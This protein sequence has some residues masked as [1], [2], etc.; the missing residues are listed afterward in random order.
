MD[1]DSGDRSNP[2]QDGENNDSGEQIPIRVSQERHRNEEK[3]PL[4]NRKQ[5]FQSRVTKRKKKSRKWK[6]STSGENPTL[7]TDSSSPSKKKTKAKVG[8]IINQ[9]RHLPQLPAIQVKRTMKKLIIDSCTNTAF[10]FN[11]KIYKQIDKVLMGFPLDPVLAN[12]IMTESEKIMVKDLV[13]ISLIEVY[14]R[15]I[16]ETLLLVKE[17]DIKFIHER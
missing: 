14:M 3:D 17:K 5:E 13:D 1:N 12:I 4:G 11:N 10:S 7:S 15:Y 8:D 9:Y 16:D 6:V 2:V